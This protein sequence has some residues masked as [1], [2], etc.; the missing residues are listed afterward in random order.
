MGPWRR[1]SPLESSLG[2]R[3]RKAASW[4]GLSKRVRSPISA[5]MVTATVSWTPRRAWRARTT[6][7]GGEVTGGQESGELHR[8]APVGLDAVAGLSGNERRGDDQAGDATTGEVAVQN[9]AA[10]PRL[11]RDDETVGLLLEPADEP[12]DV[13]RAGADAADVGDVGAAVLRNVGD[14]DGVLVNIETDEQRD[15]CLHG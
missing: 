5:S 11:V 1:E 13:G 4:R 3:P 6:V 12:V 10:R 14:R 8:I 2:T 9:V 15:G 7:A